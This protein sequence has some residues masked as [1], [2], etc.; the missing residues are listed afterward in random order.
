M[1]LFIK[2]LTSGEH[3]SMLLLQ[4]LEGFGDSAEICPDDLEEVT[5]CLLPEG[6][7]LTLVVALDDS[8]TEGNAPPAVATDFVSLVHWVLCH[9]VFPIML[10]MSQRFNLF[11]MLILPLMRK[12]CYLPTRRSCSL[13]LANNS[14]L[15]T[16]L[17][18]SNQLN[19]GILSDP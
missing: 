7:L 8:T 13:M 6:F 16:V 17:M 15:R 1:G 19:P 9:D 4:V 5:F 18:L 2:A 3:D 14:P 10:P 11:G 12:C